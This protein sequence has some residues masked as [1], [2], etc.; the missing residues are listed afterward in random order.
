MPKES[1][2]IIFP[3]I[4]LLSLFG[5]SCA[6]RSVWEYKVVD[7]VRDQ[8][9]SRTGTG[10]GKFTS[11]TPN[12]KMLNDLGKEGWELSTSYLE[13]ETAWPNFGN[14]DYVTGIQ[15]NIRPQRL[16]LVFKRIY[17]PSLSE[18]ISMKSS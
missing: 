14:A 16:V 10:S 11:V 12:E 4:L 2:V 5:I 1:R 7:V 18:K 9:A 6:K 3:A 17:Q 15:P 13:M 8:E